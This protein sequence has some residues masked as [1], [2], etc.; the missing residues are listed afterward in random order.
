MKER[1][2]GREGKREGERKRANSLVIA[3]RVHGD[4]YI[5]RISC[6]TRDVFIR[7]PSRGYGSRKEA[8]VRANGGGTPE[9]AR[10][11]TRFLV[12]RTRERENE[13]VGPSIPHGQRS[14]PA[15][16]R[17]PSLLRSAPSRTGVPSS[18]RRDRSTVSDSD[19]RRACSRECGHLTARRAIA[20]ATVRPRRDQPW[21][22]VVPRVSSHARETVLVRKRLDCQQE[23]ERRDR[24]KERESRRKRER[25][26]AAR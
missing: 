17:R 14:R 24:E 8:T 19:V 12:A 16:A 1:E 15:L 3:A 18:S 7:S 11:L 2:R 9:R 6:E 21:F 4:E 23:R 26:E 5:S 10:P 20:T 13:S 22:T 25:G